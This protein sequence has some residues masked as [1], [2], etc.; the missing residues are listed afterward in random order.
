MPSGELGNESRQN[1]ISSSKQNELSGDNEKISGEQEKESGAGKTGRLEN[2]SILLEKSHSC[3]FG[4]FIGRN[5][6]LPSI[7]RMLKSR[8]RKGSVEGFVAWRPGFIGR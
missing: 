4:L 8:L 5:S 6:R 1:K 7:A 2:H 3:H